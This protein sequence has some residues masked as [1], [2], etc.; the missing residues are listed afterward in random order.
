M[1]QTLL[2]DMFKEENIL[3]YLSALLLTKD[4]YLVWLVEELRNLLNFIV[5]KTKILL[6]SV[7]RR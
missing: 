4:V 3:I 7:L 1:K 5:E 2:R 6:F